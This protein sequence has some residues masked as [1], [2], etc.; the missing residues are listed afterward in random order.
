[1]ETM[2]YLVRTEGKIVNRAAYISLGVNKEGYK[3]ILGIW[4]GENEG[5]KFWLSVCNDL[6]NRGVEDM[7]LACID[8]LKF[9]PDA[10][11][12]FSR[13]QPFKHALSIKFVI[14]SSISAQS[15]KR[16]LLQTSS[17]YIKHHMKILTCRN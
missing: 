13:R 9:F 12:K 11:K 16:S 15:I 8:G 1:M 5:A 7:H 14:Q 6:K 10:I 17:Q 3:D 2:I 4:I